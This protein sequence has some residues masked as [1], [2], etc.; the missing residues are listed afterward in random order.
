MLDALQRLTSR[1]L[2]SSIGLPPPN[3][4]FTL[5]ILG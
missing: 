1:L 5:W 2:L 4:P 3:G